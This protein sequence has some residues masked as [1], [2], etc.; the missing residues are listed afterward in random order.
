MEI[1][2]SVFKDIEIGTEVIFKIGRGDKPVAFS[3]Y[4]KAI[5][6]KH[7][8]PLG[9]AKIKTFED[10]GRYYLVTAEHIIKDLYEGITYEEFIKVLPLH[11]YKVGFDRLLKDSENRT[12]HQIYA[13]HPD[14][15][16]CIICNT[17]DIEFGVKNHSEASQMCA[18]K[19]YLPNVGFGDLNR[20][21]RYD[22]YAQSS[23][24]AII[25]GSSS[26]VSSLLKS[27]YDTMHE[28]SNI[29][30]PIREYPDLITIYD[31]YT[32]D[33]QFDTVSIFAQNIEA[34]KFDEA[35]SIFKGSQLYAS[36]VDYYTKYLGDEFLK[37]NQ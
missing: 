2:D 35:F 6:C 31:D 22:V 21:S 7:K 24:M 28:W 3:I 17:L 8:I 19:A 32:D 12:L 20:Y 15:K 26:S 9:Y 29:K 33:S 11:G 37:R 23:G 13:Y 25:N 36:L 27:I 34:C 14:L 4:G 16:V 10:K 1:D 18:I 5:L 30:W